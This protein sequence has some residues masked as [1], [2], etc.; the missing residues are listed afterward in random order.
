MIPEWE[1][2]LRESHGKP[3]AQHQEPTGFTDGKQRIADEALQ[4]QVEAD[5]IAVLSI[6]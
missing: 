1:N 5:G 4:D 2:E 6:N 3:Q